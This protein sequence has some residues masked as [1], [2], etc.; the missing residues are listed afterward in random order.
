MDRGF[1]TPGGPTINDFRSENL[2]NPTSPLGD[3]WFRSTPSQESF[4]PK[5]LFP[6]GR[7]FNPFPTPTLEAP[8]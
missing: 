2:R 4:F 8:P 3:R 6:L 7:G 1:G 5:S